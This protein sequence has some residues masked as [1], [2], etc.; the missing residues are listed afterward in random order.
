MLHMAIKNNLGLNNF[1]GNYPTKDYE[2]LVNYIHSEDMP[3]NKEIE[4]RIN[5]K[6]YFFTH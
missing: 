5:N 2:I 4:Q 3:L 1:K 6:K